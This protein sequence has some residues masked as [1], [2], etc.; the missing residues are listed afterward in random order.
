VTTL[1]TYAAINHPTAMAGAYVA[2]GD[3]AVETLRHYFGNTGNDH[4][5]D[6]NEMVSESPEAKTHYEAIVSLFKHF[7][8][9]LPVG[10]YQITS[11]RAW[12]G[13]NHKS[14]NKNWFF[15]I[16]GYAAWIKGRVTVT[17]DNGVK[18]HVAEAE[19]KFF[20][21]YNWDGG[22]EVEIAGITITDEFMGEFHRQGLAR[23]YNNYGS[24]RRTFRWNAGDPIPPGQLNG[25]G[26]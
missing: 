17:M 25:G 15:A 24:F 16:G 4:T 12:S 7:I 13:Y 1:A 22:K 9:R 10:T 6:L 19:Y 18:H 2:I 21:R 20:D 8:E 23:E 11:K 14:Q 3:D 5:I 26:R